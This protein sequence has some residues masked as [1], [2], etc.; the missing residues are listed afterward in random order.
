MSIYYLVLPKNNYTELK[1]Q[2]KRPGRES[3]LLP[4][5]IFKIKDAC[6][7]GV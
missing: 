4:Q 1:N 6:V 5:C 7:R 2:K 3:D